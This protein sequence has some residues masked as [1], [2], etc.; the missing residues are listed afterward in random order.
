MSAYH[1][2]LR[3]DFDF[4]KTVGQAKHL[5]G[6]RLLL[7]SGDQQFQ[8][9][10]GKALAKTI[11]DLELALLNEPGVATRR[12]SGTSQNT[13]PDLSWLAGTLDVTWR[14]EDVS[15]KSNHDILSVTIR[16]PKLRVAVG[17]A[18]ITDS[19]RRMCKAEVA[20]SPAEA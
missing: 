6:N 13:V 1:R 2:P 18:R 9:K 12:G 20:E 14:N 7:R 16:G 11:E 5:A 17:K 19:D 4:D 3:R 15:L 10:R 8:S